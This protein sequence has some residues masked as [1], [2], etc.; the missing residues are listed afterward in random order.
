MLLLKELAT[1]TARKEGFSQYQ[2]SEDLLGSPSD[3]GCCLLSFEWI[4]AGEAGE[5]L[6]GSTETL[7]RTPNASACA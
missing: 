6:Q 1:L 2:E 4:N 5:G 7:E 3:A